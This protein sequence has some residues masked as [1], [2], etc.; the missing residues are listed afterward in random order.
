M[1]NY[2]IQIN[3]DQFGAHPSLV[4]SGEVLLDR[5]PILEYLYIKK[6][7]KSPHHNKEL[8]FLYTFSHFPIHCSSPY[9]S[10]LKLIVKIHI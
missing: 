2:P 5:T 9:M 3:L 6:G 1:N 10:M 8:S 4:I 7:F